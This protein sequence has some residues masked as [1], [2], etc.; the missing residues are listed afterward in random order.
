[1]YYKWRRVEW[2]RNF[3]HY[4]N[5]HLN[6]YSFLFFPFYALYNSWRN[7]SCL[8]RLTE[9][10]LSQGAYDL[11]IPR[12]D[13]HSAWSYRITMDDSE[14]IVLV[15]DFSHYKK[16]VEGLGLIHMIK[17]DAYYRKKD[18]STIIN[19]YELADHRNKLPHI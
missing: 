9:D 4:Y 7:N 15:H 11:I 3:D 17:R 16:Q 13:I 14:V 18:W 2:I 8:L 6:P 10:H 12:E 1:M 19:P 5:D